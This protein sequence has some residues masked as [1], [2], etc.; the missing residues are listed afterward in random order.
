[1]DIEDGSAKLKGPSVSKLRN[2]IKALGSTVELH[3]RYYQLATQLLHRFTFTSQTERRVWELHCDGLE[4]TEISP[5]VRLSPY[6]V[7]KIVRS[8]AAHLNFE[9]D[10]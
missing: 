8:I 6:M 9:D 2:H 10:F 5:R 1:V 7:G 3:A 4:H